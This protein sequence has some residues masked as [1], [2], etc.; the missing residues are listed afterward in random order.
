MTKFAAFSS[1]SLTGVYFASILL[2]LV[3][4]ACGYLVGRGIGRRRKAR[5]EDASMGSAVAATLGLLAFMLALTFNMTADRFG[6]RK[7][8]LLDEV[9]AIGTTFLR[10]DFL[11]ADNRARARELLREYVSLRSFDPRAMTADDFRR[12]ILRSEQVH[13]ALWALVEREIAVGTDA[14]RLRAFY[15]P[16]NQLIDLH[17]TR[18][19]VGLAYQVPVPIW[20]A[21][22][23]I[24]ALAVFG[25]GFQL[26]VSG[27]GSKLVALAM[28]MA[29]SLVILL[30]ADLDRAGEGM[31][32]VDQ[33]P[34]KELG[35]QLRSRPDD[36]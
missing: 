13:R 20:A 12:D 7:A 26:G 29:F 36:R 4:L 9:N 32:V 6:Q 3:A 5:G 2:V 28:A 34:M 35:E 16:L 22:Y 1:I 17:T 8:M 19:Q 30:I 25:I 10:T 33:A 14:N 21:L 24:S 15:E 18:V 27:S 31:L 11:N 23:A